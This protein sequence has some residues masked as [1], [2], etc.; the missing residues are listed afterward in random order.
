[1]I[2]TVPLTAADKRRKVDGGIKSE[3]A[4]DRDPMKLDV[5]ESTFVGL[6]TRDPKT[7]AE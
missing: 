4:P 1:M 5:T 3:R 2:E 6:K 7:C